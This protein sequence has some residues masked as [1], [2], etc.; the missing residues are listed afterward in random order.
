MINLYAR[1]VIL[2]L[3]VF[4]P[5]MASTQGDSGVMRGTVFGPNGETVPDMPIQA[6]HAGS[7]EYERT[8]SA[9][10]GQFMLTSLAAGSYTLTISTPCCAYQRYKNEEIVVAAGETT[11]LEIHLEE[12]VYFATLADDPSVLAAVIRKRQEI[13]DLPVP[14]LPNGNPNLSGMWMIGEDPYPQGADAHPWAEELFAERIA[15]DLADLPHRRC[16]PGGPPIPT[17]VAPFLGKF[18]QTADLLVILFEDVPGFDKYF[19]TGVNTPMT[20]IQAG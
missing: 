14:R 15:N 2:G 18:V 11:S 19:L 3:T 9:A 1:I 20:P 4:M 7:G 5:S 17:L 10:N 16:L 13:P 6:T 8:Q 12:S